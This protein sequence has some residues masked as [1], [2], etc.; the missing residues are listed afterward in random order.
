MNLEPRTYK[1][2]IKMATVD[3]YGEY[4]QMNGWLCCFED[5]FD[6]PVEASMLGVDVKVVGFDMIADAAV[7]AV[8][9]KNRKKANVEIMDLEF[10]KLSKTQKMWIKA[11]E[12]VEQQPLNSLKMAITNDNRY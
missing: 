9:E 12:G 6:L 8:C 10:K 2:C 11:L 4:E 7:V 5:V 1:D 3:A